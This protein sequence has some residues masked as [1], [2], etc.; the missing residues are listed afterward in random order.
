MLSQLPHFSFS[1]FPECVCM[2]VRVSVCV[3][4][5]LFYTLLADIQKNTCPLFEFKAS[6][7]FI[8]FIF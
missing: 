2:C 4:E 3:S 1:T 6:Y 5:V 7:L 8:Y